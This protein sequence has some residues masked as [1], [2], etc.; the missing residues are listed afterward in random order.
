MSFHRM[1]F[2]INWLLYASSRASAPI[3]R[4]YGGIETSASRR[5]EIISVK[6]RAFRAASGEGGGASAGSMLRFVAGEMPGSAAPDCGHAP[7]EMEIKLSKC[8]QP[9]DKL[10]ARGWPP[11]FCRLSLMVL[12]HAH[13]AG[14]SI[15]F[16]RRSRPCV[17]RNVIKRHHRSSKS[18][19][20]C[21]LPSVMACEARQHPRP[22]APR[23]IHASPAR[24][25]S[26][27]FGEAA[28]MRRSS[29]LK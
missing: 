23:T 17:R 13:H 15:L 28:T 7:L 20:S 1:T 18:R 9:A 25:R 4:A 3:A 19:A 24:A 16:C 21:E 10:A 27:R 22:K 6:C 8:R 11:T 2:Y 26:C 14:G 5:A 12:C 29:P